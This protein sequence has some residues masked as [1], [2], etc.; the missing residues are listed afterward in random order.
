MKVKEVRRKV[1]E[2]SDEEAGKEQSVYGRPE[3]MKSRA[4]E[5]YFVRD[6]KRNLVY[7][8]AGEIL[9]QK[10]VKKNGN[11]RYANKNAC[12]HCKNRNKC[13]KGKNEWKEI[14]FTKD[15]LEKPCRDWLKAE[16]KP[17]E[18]QRKKGKGHY[19]KKKVVTL[20]LKPDPQKAEKRMSLSE[21]PFGTIKRAMRAAYF[22]LRSLRKVSGEFALM[23]LG[24][25][26]ERAK[27][28]LGFAKI[29]RLVA[30]A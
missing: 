18:L 3:E 17:Y 10:S 28:L 29:M 8:S 24:Y 23:C 21:H 12:R 19:E 9:R 7:C 26:I 5:G 6:P 14:D 15:C 22:L 4:K 20:I 2:E 11:I 30:E 1:T 25:N 13:Y 16:G 27:N